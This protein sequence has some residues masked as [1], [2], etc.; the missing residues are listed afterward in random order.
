MLGQYF[1]QQIVKAKDKGSPCFDYILLLFL[2]T[3]QLF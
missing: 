2:Q 1:E 3:E